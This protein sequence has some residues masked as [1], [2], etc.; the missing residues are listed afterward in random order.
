MVYTLTLNPSIDYY[1]ELDTL[2]VG[3]LNRSKGEYMCAGGKGI[4]VSLMLK[5]LGI[6]STAIG[7]IGGF[8]GDEI[9][10]SLKDKGI[11]SDLTITES[12]CS[13]INVKI[14]S[15]G[16]LETEVNGKG[17]IVSKEDIDRLYDKLGEL[18]KSDI[19]VISGSVCEGFDENAYAGIVSFLA[20]RNVYTIVDA[21]GPLLKNAAKAG[22]FLVKPNLCELA[23]LYKTGAGDAIT[24]D[25]I[26]TYAKRLIEE[27]VKNVLVSM[28]EYGALMVTENM[29]IYKEGIPDIRTD[30]RA[31]SNVV[32][33]VGAG[34]S[35]LAGFIAEYFYGSHK[36]EDALKKAVHAGTLTALG[37]G[38][39]A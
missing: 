23:G 22:P 29:E 10:R 30:N 38:L 16:G 26:I 19:L 5:S 36:Y 34:D 31:K 24:G 13:R 18:K 25:E 2:M 15:A 21:S 14:S 35:L 17:V 3:G 33:T 6:E 8:T 20:D 28:G 27:G 11:K 9:Q 1:V 39:H 4:N 7:F 12:G 32:S 37:L